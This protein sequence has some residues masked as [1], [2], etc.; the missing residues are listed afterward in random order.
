MGAQAE[1]GFPVLPGS[2]SGVLAF[3]GCFR[4]HRGGIGTIVYVL[5][6]DFIS[7]KTNSVRMSSNL[8]E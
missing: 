4:L 8:V 3:L 1:I 6:S 7:D 2:T 5:P